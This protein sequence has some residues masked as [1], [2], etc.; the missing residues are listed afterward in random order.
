[1]GKALYRKYRSKKLSE[2]VGQDHITST[3]QNALKSGQISHAY[4]LTGPRGTGKTSVARILAHEVNKLPYDD[5]SMHLDII[6]IDAASNRRIDEIRDLR[7][8]VNLAPTSAKYKVYIIDEVHMLT[9]EAFNALLKTLEEP[10]EHV[11]FILA[12]TEL[13]KLPDTIISRTQRYGFKPIN[14]EDMIPHLRHIAIAEKLTV[15]DEALSSI[16]IHARGSFRDAISLLDQASGS[17]KSI[18][19]ASIENLLGLAPAKQIEKC[20][21]AILEQDGYGALDITAN[22]I[23]SGHSPETLAAQLIAVARELLLGG[24]S[25][26]ALL[27]FMSDLLEVTR[28]SN[29]G[30][31][32]ELAILKVAGTKGA[33]LEPVEKVIHKELNPVEDKKPTK[34]PEKIAEIKPVI[35]AAKEVVKSLNSG[36]V[37]KLWQETLEKIKGQHNTLYG[38]LRMADLRITKPLELSLGF[39]FPFHMKRASEARHLEVITK[40]LKLISGKDYAIQFVKRT[41]ES[42]KPDKQKPVAEKKESAAL[43]TIRDVFGEAELL[44]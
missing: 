38:I 11:I 17:E 26:D 23:E 9:R 10:P 39:Q 4:L 33:T 6:E 14:P 35:E 7:E 15:D 24:E 28:S 2:V 20:M 16:A 13:H 36:K 37:E 41:M 21:K 22:L 27:G 44:H 31:A 40:T 8:K 34:T 42:P 1:M 18:T 25:P 5:D 3:L 29:A 19:A 32:L 43:N 30:I 12:T